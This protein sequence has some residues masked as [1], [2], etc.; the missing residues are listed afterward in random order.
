MPGARQRWQL[1][2]YNTTLVRFSGMLLRLNDTVIMQKSC[3]VEPQFVSQTHPLWW[4]GWRPDVN[5]L[6]HNLCLVD[7]A[8]HLLPAA[9]VPCCTH[10][11]RL[12]VNC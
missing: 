11:C 9:A 4:H 3:H 7:A 10:S 1:Q 2:M 5:L 8:H 12:Q 6:G